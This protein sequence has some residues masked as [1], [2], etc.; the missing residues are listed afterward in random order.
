MSKYASIEELRAARDLQ[1]ART[2]YLLLPDHKLSDTGLTL[3]LIYRQYLR[4]ITS[5]YTDDTVTQAIIQPT[6]TRDMLYQ[7]E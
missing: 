4:D 3:L 5:M 1:L 6:P 2:D 7:I